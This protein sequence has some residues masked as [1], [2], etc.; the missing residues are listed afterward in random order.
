MTASSDWSVRG[1]DRGREVHEIAPVGHQD[2]RFPRRSPNG[3]RR[4]RGP[5]HP[6]ADP[7][8]SPAPAEATDDRTDPN[9]DNGSATSS[10]DHVIDTLA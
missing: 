7:D 6:A 9:A 1:P 4:K 10:G 5:Q 2:K 8:A 3:N